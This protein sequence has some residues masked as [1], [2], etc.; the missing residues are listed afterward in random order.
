MEPHLAPGKGSLGISNLLGNSTSEFEAGLKCNLES[1]TRVL[2]LILINYG[3]TTSEL[4]H[5]LQQLYLVVISIW[6]LVPH[7]P[8][9]S[10]LISRKVITV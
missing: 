4:L 9:Q 6:A 5:G 2:R 1:L 3:V 7:F 8:T 10:Y